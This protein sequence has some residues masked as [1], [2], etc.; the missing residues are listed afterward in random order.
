VGTRD[1][2]NGY[3]EDVYEDRPV[4]DEVE[5]TETYQEPVYRQVPVYRMRYSFTIDEW[6]TLREEKST[7]EDL[8]PYWPDTD[9]ADGEREGERRESYT[10]IFRAPD[11]E[12]FEQEVKTEEEFLGHQEGRPYRADTKWLGGIKRIV[13]PAGPP[14]GE[15][16]ATPAP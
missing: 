5:S 4:Y 16:P 9:L 11:G 2:G 7:G 6:Q 13:G 3:F 12:T 14:P 15:E 10:V 1:L 8:A